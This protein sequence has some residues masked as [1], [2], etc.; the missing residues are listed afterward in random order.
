MVNVTTHNGLTLLELDAD[1]AK[2]GSD[3]DAQSETR[4]VK[5]MDI[6]ELF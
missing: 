1:G 6:A 5:Y 2:L 3:R 4:N